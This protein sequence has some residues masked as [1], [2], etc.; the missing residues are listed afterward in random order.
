MSKDFDTGD[1]GFWGQNNPNI[2]NKLITK[3]K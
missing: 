2:L 1:V 3:D